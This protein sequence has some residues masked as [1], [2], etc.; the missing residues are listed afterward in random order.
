M[1]LLGEVEKR[2]MTQ[3]LRSSHLRVLL[4]GGRIPALRSLSEMINGDL[5]VQIQLPIGLGGLEDNSNLTKQVTRYS[6]S[7]ETKATLQRD[8][9]YLSAREISVLQRVNVQKSTF[10]PYIRS[11]SNGLVE[12]PVPERRTWALGYIHEIFQYISNSGTES[13]LAC[14]ARCVDVED[15]FLPNDIE[16]GARLYGRDVADYV[17]VPVHHLH[18]VVRYP[19]SIRAQL[20]IS[21]HNFI[22]S[23]ED[24]NVELDLEAEDE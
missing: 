5:D 9:V 14:I 4:A 21:T 15:R 10:E 12:Y 2:F 1:N 23:D 17:L 11:R 13:M 6:I 8:G 20:V 22:I 18:H 16:L 19:W 7:S 24:D 3:W